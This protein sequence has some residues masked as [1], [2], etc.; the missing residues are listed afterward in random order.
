[1]W[2]TFIKRQKVQEVFRAWKHGSFNVAD[3]H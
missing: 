3:A 1:M 2:P